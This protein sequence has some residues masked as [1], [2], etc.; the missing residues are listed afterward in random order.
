MV[1]TYEATIVCPHCGGEVLIERDLPKRRGMLAGKTL[2]EMTDE[3]LKI[4]IRNAKS[5]LYKAQQKN[6]NEETILRNKVRVEAA[7][8]EREKRE[9]AKKEAEVEEAEVEEAE[10]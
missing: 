1:E 6:A 5:A 2:E 8:A 7:L 10:M 4:E 9:A 3:E